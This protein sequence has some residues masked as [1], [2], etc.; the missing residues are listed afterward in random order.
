M[1]T[2]KNPNICVTQIYQ[3]KKLNRIL[4]KTIL[5]LVLL[6]S[7]G[8]KIKTQDIYIANHNILPLFVNPATTGM[9]FGEPVLSRAMFN[10]SNGSFGGS[11]I[12]LHTAS[13]GYDKN[14]DKFGLGGY[15]INS[16]GG[17]AYLNTLN[18]M[19]SGAYEISLDPSYKH[20][21]WGGVQLGF[22]QNY[23]NIDGIWFESQ[24]SD[25]TIDRSSTGGEIIDQNQFIFDFGLGALYTFKDEQKAFNPFAGLAIY[26][27]YT[28]NASNLSAKYVY[29]YRISLNI[30]TKINFD[31]LRFSPEYL[32]M[33]QAL[34][35]LHKIGSY[36]DYTLS[37]NLNLSIGGYYNTLRLSE[38]HLGMIHNHIKYQISY[39]FASSKDPS[40][41]NISILEFSLLIYS[42]SES[43]PSY[44]LK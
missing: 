43:I 42:I 44:L 8:N 15:V 38:I 18:I 4:G 32:F 27:P 6:L 20:N 13:I 21:L 28:K 34:I 11:N 9:Y 24:Y 36:V 14:F 7:L 16:N 2:S 37:D 35:Q 30:G 3:M 22:I 26:H 12:N 39:S 1:A 17:G 5:I 23:I 41:T 31:K 25:G 19:L 40:S 10:Y 33:Q 29:P